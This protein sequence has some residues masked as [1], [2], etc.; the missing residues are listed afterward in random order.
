MTHNDD[1]RGRMTCSV[2]VSPSVVDAGAGLTLRGRVSC[3]PA[4]DLRGRFLLV[5]DQAGAELGRA[6]LTTSNAGTSETSELFLKAPTEAGEY[7]WLVVCPAVVKGDVSYA[8]ASAPV[9]FTVTRHATHVVAWDV[10]PAIVVG[11]RFR[12]KV[13]I[14]CSSECQLANRPFEILNHE[15]AVVATGSVSG[16][17]WPGTTAL[18][19][20][21]AELEAPAEEGLFTWSVKVPPSDVGVPHAEGVV[22][23]GVRAVSH[24]DCLVRVEVVDKDSRA[25]LP[26]ARVVMHPFRALTDD[27]GFAQLRVATGAYTLFVSQTRYLTFGLSV[28]VTADMTASAELCLEPEPE[29]N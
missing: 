15:G 6:E 11:E 28:E 9:S 2:D 29:R 18:C 10:P 22:S 21:E 1:P 3:S 14:G 7:A 16:D 24:Q 20:G 25:P 23:V 4:C 26:G 17:I 19:V 13:G 12:M 8:E 27:R 5:T